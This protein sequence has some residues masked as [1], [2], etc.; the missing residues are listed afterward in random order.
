MKRVISLLV[1][2]FLLTSVVAYASY[3]SGMELQYAYTTP[4]HSGYPYFH[5]VFEVDWES[6]YPDPPLDGS[7]F[8]LT[9]WLSENICEG[10]GTPATTCSTLCHAHLQDS[11]MTPYY[12]ECTFEWQSDEWYMLVSEYEYCPIV[13]WYEGPEDWDMIWY[14]GDTTLCA[15]W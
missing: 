15:D 14:S 1:M 10:I 6:T 2:L 5:I 11:P 12:V 3:D 7:G 9:N 4:V 8:I 13:V